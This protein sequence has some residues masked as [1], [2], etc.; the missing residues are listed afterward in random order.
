M[1]DEIPSPKA[2]AEA[3]AE[4]EVDTENE[5]DKEDPLCS[6]GYLMKKSIGQSN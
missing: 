5:D 2:E 3:E 4:A 1:V 6:T